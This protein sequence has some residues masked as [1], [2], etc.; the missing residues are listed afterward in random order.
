MGEGE[1][2][3]VLLGGGWL[4]GGMEGG[5]TV[6]KRKEGDEGWLEIETCM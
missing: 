2:R 3:V 5:E 6:S 4:E 1:S